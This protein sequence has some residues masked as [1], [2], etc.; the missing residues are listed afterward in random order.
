[1]A[2]STPVDIGQWIE[3]GVRVR[4]EPVVSV[5]QKT[6]IGHEARLAEDGLGDIR[7]LAAEQNRAV[8]FDR[9][10]RRAALEAFRQLPPD[11]GLCFLSFESA[12]LDLGVAGSG[13]VASAVEELGLTPSE[14]AL[15]VRESPVED[16][17]ALKRFVT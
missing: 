15:S 2:M 5:R 17:E 8:D 6:V 10:F 9:A 1:M 12:V 4:M 14:V 7:A 16:G 13:R 3:R 11:R